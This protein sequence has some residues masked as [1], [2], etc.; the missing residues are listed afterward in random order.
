MQALIVA[1]CAFVLAVV[2]GKLIIPALRALHAGQS[3]REIGPS[4]HNSK[5]GTPTMGGIAFI[6]S[7]LVCTLAFGWKDMLEGEY[8]HLLVFGFALIYGLIGFADDFLKVR[9]KR[10]LGLTT[11]RPGPASPARPRPWRW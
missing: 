5:A 11:A 1:A 2:F 6:L 7:T 9:F 4:W 3:I 10:N 8:T